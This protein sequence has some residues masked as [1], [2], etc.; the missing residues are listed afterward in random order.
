MS[1]RWFHI[2]GFN[3]LWI[4]FPLYVL[5][6]AYLDISEK[7]R[8]VETKGYGWNEDRDGVIGDRKSR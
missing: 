2:V 6:S 3:A 8:V 4:F 5:R 7:F 1:V